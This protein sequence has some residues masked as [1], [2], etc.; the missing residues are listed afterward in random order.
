LVFTT[1][2]ERI[3]GMVSLRR[4]ARIQPNVTTLSRDGFEVSATVVTIFSL[5][6]PPEVVRVGYAP[7]APD[8]PNPFRPENL[9][10]I[11]VDEKTNTIQGFRDE[12]DLA[13]QREVH[14]F[15]QRTNP[16]PRP[17]RG[18][19]RRLQPRSPYHF[20][21]ERVFKAVYSDARRISD[22]SVENWLD[23]PLRVA[24]ETFH[25]M[26]ASV[27]Y[28]DLYMPKDPKAFP[29]FQE[30]RPQFGRAVRN[31]GVLSFQLILRKDDLPLA[32]G[33]TWEENDLEIF[34]V[35]PLRSTKVLRDRGIRVIAATFSELKPVKPEVRQQLLDYWRAR[36]DH[37]ADLT[38][39]PY[40][41][42][43]IMVQARARA[44]AQR[45]IVESLHKVLEDTSITSE[46]M[47]VQVL[48]ALESFAKDPATETL[49]P[50][51]TLS[52]LSNLHEWLWRQA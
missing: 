24:V 44:L 5:G 46:T 51:E 8:D 30:F 19:E 50:G 20:D 25:N 48:Q 3:R 22:D 2:G 11:Q 40:D 12:L 34:P 29:L 47:A 39:A 49:L 4:Q 43:E 41:Y 1:G 18:R 10:A 7:A 14:L 37:Q 15:A 27:R 21:P 36:R 32:V 9:R 31:Q 26:L 42:Q 16:A 28:T 45:D 33:Q 23:M 17:R 38:R 35:Q 13:D 52:M 6:E